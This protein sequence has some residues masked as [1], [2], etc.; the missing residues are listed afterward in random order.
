M[1]SIIYIFSVAVYVHWGVEVFPGSWLGL[2]SVFF[3]ALSS[4]LGVVVLSHCQPRGCLSASNTSAILSFWQPPRAWCCQQVGHFQLCPRESVI[5]RKHLHR[6]LFWLW[7]VVGTQAHWQLG[8]PGKAP[9]SFTPA[10]VPFPTFQSRC[11]PIREMG[12]EQ[13]HGKMWD[14]I[15]C[16]H[17]KTPCSCQLWPAKSKPEPELSQGGWAWG[18]RVLYANCPG[19]LLPKGRWLMLCPSTNP[20]QHFLGPWWIVELFP[21]SQHLKTRK[22]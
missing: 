7:L 17:S 3:S 10:H 19:P 9:A 18:Q 1:W 5:V 6:F 8:K 20:S 4:S 21:P 13:S 15:G 2:R 12:L 11:F 16:L 14:S 22:K